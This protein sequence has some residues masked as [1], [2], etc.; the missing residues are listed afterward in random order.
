MSMKQNESKPKNTARNVTIL[1]AVL[2]AIVVAASVAVLLHGRDGGAPTGNASQSQAASGADSS[3]ETVEG[4]LS[5]NGAWYVPKENIE[6]ILFM[7]L[8]KFED[9]IRQQNGY[10][11][12]QQADF[13]LLLVIDLRPAIVRRS[14]STGI[15]CARSRSWAWQEMPFR[16]PLPSWRWPIPMA[17]AALTAVSTRKRPF[18]NCSMA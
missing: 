8:D 5:Y 18:P 13:N 16:E 1:I 7:G 2:A 3:D 4:E 9:Q 11:N 10:M 12:D 17:A 6:T 14:S 15:P